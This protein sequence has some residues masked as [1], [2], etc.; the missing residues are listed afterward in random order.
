MKI[1]KH[2]FKLNA[3]GSFYQDI[4][5]EFWLF[6]QPVPFSEPGS[7]IRNN[8]YKKYHEVPRHVLQ[9]PYIWM[10]LS[11]WLKTSIRTGFH[12]NWYM[13]KTSSIML[14]FLR[15]VFQFRGSLQAYLHHEPCTTPFLRPREDL[16]RIGGDILRGSTSFSVI[17]PLQTSCRLPFLKA[18]FGLTR[19]RR[20]ARTEVLIMR[21]CSHS[22]VTYKEKC[23]HLGHQFATCIPK[24]FVRVVWAFC[25]PYHDVTKPVR[26]N[27]HVY[28]NQ[29]KRKNND[30]SLG[31]HT[32]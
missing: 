5:D 11:S 19:E 17:H 4:F 3:S 10:T 20:K 13:C 30:G 27:I 21:T 2:F 24:N 23:S 26:G 31:N 6:I 9:K 15:F 7:S 29:R 22:L 16:R 28:K 8:Y 25:V 32:S 18:G 14:V 12:L 1:F